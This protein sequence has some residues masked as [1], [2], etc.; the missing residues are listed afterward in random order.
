MTELSTSLGISKQQTTKL[1]EKLYL[2]H[3]IERVLDKL[4]HRIIYIKITE[5][6]TNYLTIYQQQLTFLNPI[7]EKLS[8]DEKIEFYQSI[9]RMIQILTKK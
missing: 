5:E 7:M 1:I 6:A 8:D 9:Q 2:C 3:F 4:D